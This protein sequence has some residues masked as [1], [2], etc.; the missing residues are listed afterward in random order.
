MGVSTDMRFLLRLARAAV[1]GQRPLLPNPL[2]GGNAAPAMLALLGALQS[3][4]SRRGRPRTT[5][6][7]IGFLWVGKCESIWLASVPCHVLLAMLVRDKTLR[8]MRV[9]RR[10][11]PALRFGYSPGQRGATLLCK[12][13]PVP[14]RDEEY[15]AA[16]PLLDR[17]DA[18]LAQALNAGNGSRPVLHSPH[19]LEYT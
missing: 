3:K 19:A 15:L 13:V 5:S 8:F 18:G 16:P 10:C 7:R 17:P 4:A 6:G 9:T 12:K 11:R 2:R 14:T 1:H